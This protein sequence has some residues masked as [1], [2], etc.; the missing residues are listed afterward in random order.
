MQTEEFTNAEFDPHQIKEVSD[1]ENF[2]IQPSP[3]NPPWNSLTAILFW[4]VS[5]LLIGIFPF[6]LIIPYALQQN[7]NLTEQNALAEL[8]RNDPNAIILNVAA[9]FPAHLLTFF[10][11]WLIITRYKKYSFFQMIGWKWGG[12]KFWHG[13]VILIG[14]FAIAAIVS[15]FIPEQENDLIKILKSS[16]T[17]MI[18]VVIIAT[19]SAPLIEEI[20]YRGILYSAFQRTFGVA[21]AVFSVTM[22]FAVVH[23]PQYYPSYSTIILI[24][25]LSLILTLVRVKTDN[26]LPCVALHFVFNGLQSFFLLLEPYIPKNPTEIHNAPAFL[27]RFLT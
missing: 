15:N 23:V 4:I 2:K 13:F 20:V 11:A 8:I 14:F 12:F 25:I 3:N 26:L 24:F 18:L 1:V 16:Q 6:F 10:G 17:A 22:L 21:A 9:V 27:I 19:F 7:V 5:V